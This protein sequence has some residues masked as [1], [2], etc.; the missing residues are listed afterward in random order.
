MTVRGYAGSLPPARQP[1]HHVP[2]LTLQRAT[3]VSTFG[4]PVSPEGHTMPRGDAAKA[5]T[6][7]RGPTD[8]PQGIHEKRLRPQTEARGKL[9][10]LFTNLSPK[11]SVSFGEKNEQ[12]L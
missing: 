1:G 2:L 12:Y 9:I 10:F 11:C 5:R 4:I 7:H 8:P 3:S 6:P